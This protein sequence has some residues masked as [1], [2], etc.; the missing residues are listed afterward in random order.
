MSSESPD[1]S[2]ADF[3]TAI[4]ATSFGKFNLLLLLVT[5][6]AGWASAFDTG[7]MSYVFPAAQCDLQ[8]TLENKGTLNA[9]I[10]AGK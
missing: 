1:S 10:F 9:I 4:A 7:V 8:L 3:E 5:L 6:P 2:V